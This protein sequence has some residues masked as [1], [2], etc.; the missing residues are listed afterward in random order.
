MKKSSAL[1]K[2]EANFHVNKQQFFIVSGSLQWCNDAH[3]SG[4]LSTGEAKKRVK[5]KKVLEG[6]DL[7]ILST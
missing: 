1:L 2:V 7:I 5:K 4:S 6:L 3:L